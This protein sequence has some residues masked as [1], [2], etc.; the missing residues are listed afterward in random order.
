MWQEALVNLLAARALCNAALPTKPS[1]PY[2]APWLAGNPAQLTGL[3]TVDRA[4]RK[5][6]GQ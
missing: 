2:K 3:Q 1:D 6:L 4:Q 5:M